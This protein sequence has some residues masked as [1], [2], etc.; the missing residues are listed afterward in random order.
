MATE[1]Q[2]SG[3]RELLDGYLKEIRLH[4]PL[5]RAEE[6]DLAVRARAGDRRAARKLVT[7]NLAF[8]VA[9]ARRQRL[10]SLRLEDVIQEGNLG[11]L[12]AVEKFDPEAGTRFS[13]YAVWWIRAYIGKHLKEAR[14]SVRPLSGT[15]AQADLSLDTT[16]DEEGEVTHLE[17]I[18]DPGPGPEEVAVSAQNVKKVRRSLTRLRKRLGEVGWDVVHARLERDEPVTLD[19]IGRRWGVSR[20]R[21]RQIELRTKDTLR[22]ALAEELER[23]AA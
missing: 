13:T 5:G 9:V 3:S 10:G 16:V 1:T 6:H 2:G 11:L 20:E 8:V 17:R 7:H 18:E 15:V 14:S 19:E 22:R 23:E 21:V 4:P 12:R